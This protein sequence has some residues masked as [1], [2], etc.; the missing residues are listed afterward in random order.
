MW[1]LPHH[2][3]LRPLAH[4]VPRNAIACTQQHALA[5]ARVNIVR[6]RIRCVR[7]RHRRGCRCRVAIRRRD[8]H[9]RGQFLSARQ[10]VVTDSK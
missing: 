3:T 8:L 7:G 1:K 4:L 2:C 6:V 5:P 10:A 9:T